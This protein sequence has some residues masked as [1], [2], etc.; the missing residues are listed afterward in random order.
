MILRCFEC[1]K[2]QSDIFSYMKMSTGYYQKNKKKLRKEAHE[3][4][5]NISEEEKKKPS[6]SS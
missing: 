1:K 2:N 3:K 6:V 5:Q 4:Y